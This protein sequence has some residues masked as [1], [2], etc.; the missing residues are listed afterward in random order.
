MT[1]AL[2]ESWLINN[3]VTLHLIQGLTPEALACTLSTR[4]GRNV[5][6]QLVHVY[7]VRR[8]KVE[9]ADKELAKNLPRV[10]REQGD[11]QALLLDVFNRS[12]EAI[13]EIIRK[14][15]ETDGHVKGFK[16][17]IAA[18]VGYFIAHDAHHRGGIL[19][20]MK[21]CKVKR[22]QELQ[23]GLWAWNQI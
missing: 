8:V 18:L 13:A 20:T 7:E 2:A 11:D 12:G 23:M 22:P 1:N 19:V 16:R 3:R 15:A 9:Q 17:G 5:G 10:E 6:Q 21:Q 14:S 4:G